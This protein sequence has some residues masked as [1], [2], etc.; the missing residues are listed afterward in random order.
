M[1]DYDG[2]GWDF[3]SDEFWTTQTE[4]VSRAGKPTGDTEPQP[5]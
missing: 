5:C 2:P 4:K 3:D 1:D